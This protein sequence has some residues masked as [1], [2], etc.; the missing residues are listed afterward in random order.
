MPYGEN[1]RVDKLH[2]GKHFGAVSRKFNIN[3]LPT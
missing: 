2:V 1:T 3:E